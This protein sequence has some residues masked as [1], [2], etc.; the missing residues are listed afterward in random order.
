MRRSSDEAGA[1]G[2][3][4]S[5]HLELEPIAT[6]SCVAACISALCMRNLSRSMMLPPQ[7]RLF[8]ILAWGVGAKEQAM[9]NFRM[10]LSRMHG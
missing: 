2:A 10:E 4:Q 9:R 6:E 7:L 5:G 8:K 1:H 3:Q